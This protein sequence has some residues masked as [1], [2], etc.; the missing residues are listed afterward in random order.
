[1]MK[2][3]REF[4]CALLSAALIL[5]AAGCMAT[6]G[7]SQGASASESAETAAANTTAPATSQ[8]ASS[9]AE[10][11]E[12]PAGDFHYRVEGDHIVLEEYIGS[13]SSMVIPAEI[14]G[15]PVVELAEL[16]FCRAAVTTVVIPGSVK[17]FGGAFNINSSIKTVIIREGVTAV[18]SAAFEGCEA[19][20][21]VS[22]P[23]TVTA[24][25]SNAFYCCSNLRDIRL[26]DAL[27]SIG[28]AA[29][30][31]CFALKTFFIPAS[32][33][34]I[35]LEAVFTHCT[36]LSAFE[37]AEDNPAYT[38]VDGVL[39]S[40]DMKTLIS[41]PCSRPAK[42]YA[43]P[44]TVRHLAKCSFFVPQDLKQLRLPEGIT[45]FDNDVLCTYSSPFLLVLPSSVTSI[46]EELP[47]D[48]TNLRIGGKT[49]SY[50]QEYALKHGLEFKDTE[51]A[52]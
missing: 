12:N 20:T 31:N 21:T 14:E 5:A 10:L 32:V 2:I 46:G 19:L 28:A 37:A 7:V 1:M 35:S 52:A 26:P 8:A 51:A 45:I 4:S 33:T 44:D 39:F 6:E 11:P 16:G 50:A 34:D 17:S 48:N 23:S 41:Y 30:G 18:S 25:E 22:L 38:T 27:I 9:P 13:S 43:V 15:K 3:S 49:G 36:S 24:I 29:F 47:Y 42:E 40:K